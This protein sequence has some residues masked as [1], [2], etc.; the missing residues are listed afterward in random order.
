[1]NGPDA[2]PDRDEWPGYW[3]VIRTAA[4]WLL[5]AAVVVGGGT[6]ILRPADDVGGFAVRF[7]I[8]VLAAL[9]STSLARLV[10]DRWDRRRERP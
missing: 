10:N 8:G 2:Y 4:A 7:A 5:V 6:T 9:A 1:V 3:R